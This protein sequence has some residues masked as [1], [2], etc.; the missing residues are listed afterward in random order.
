MH[1]RVFER[2]AFNHIY[3]Q[4]LSKSAATEE[5]T[6]IKLTVSGGLMLLPAS[7]F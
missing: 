6:P 5:D 2:E 3:N 7:N 1:W 4:R